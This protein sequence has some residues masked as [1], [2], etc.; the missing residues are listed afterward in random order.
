MFKENKDFFLYIIGIVAFL[1]ISVF[2]LNVYL[3]SPSSNETEEGSVETG[4][5]SCGFLGLGCFLN[6][7]SGDGYEIK[8]YSEYPNMGIN[9]E[10]DYRVIIKTNKGDFTIDLFEKNAPKAVNSFLFLV[11]EDFYDDVYFHRVIDNLLIQTGDRNTL[12]SNP[13]NDGQG[14]SGYT[15]EDEVNWDSLSFSKAKRQQ[16]KNLGYSTNKDVRSKHL[17]QKSVAMANGGPNTNGSQFFIIMASS[18]DSLVRGLEGRHTVFG[19]VVSGWKVVEEISNS[20]VDN[21]SS[22][23]PK[24]LENIYI[25]DIEFFSK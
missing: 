20:K 14:G 2:V 17:E 7:F 23:S 25:T 16:L 3:E 21:P 11:T 4:S 10:K 5:E 9:T 12:D 13:D 19:K 8:Q 24:P 18:D 1:V 6:S 22:S 15:F